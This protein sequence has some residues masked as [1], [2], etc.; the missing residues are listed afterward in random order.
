MP[1]DTCA[2]RFL[3][4][5]GR[6][7]NHLSSISTTRS[8][9]GMP[10]FA[11]LLASTAALGMAFSF[12]VPFLSLWGTTRIGLTP[13]QFGAF[14]TAVT[15]SSVTWSIGIGHWSDRHSTRRTLLLLGGAGGML[16]YAGYAF[17]TE[18]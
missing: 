14:M 16:G 4:P 10:S 11:G 18:P 17:V 6:T 13:V 5:T 7:F 15:L 1:W 3:Q 12:V 2:P 9:L 8:L